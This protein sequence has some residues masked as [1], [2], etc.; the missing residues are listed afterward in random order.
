MNMVMMGVS[1]AAGA[2]TAETVVF[3]PS[4]NP[5][6]NSIG[7]FATAVFTLN[8]NGNYNSA[9]AGG[10]GTWANDTVED[11]SLF[12]ARGVQISGDTVTG[13]DSVWRVLTGGQSYTLTSG[14]SGAT[15][16]GD[17]DVEVRQIANTNNTDTLRVT[18]TAINENL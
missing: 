14:T 13:A 8:S 12:E 3:T 4:T 7:A 11:A 1:A 18:L 10:S 2:S 15:L 16:A 5:S 6:V 17:I 9:D